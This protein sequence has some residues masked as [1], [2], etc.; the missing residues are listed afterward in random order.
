MCRPDYALTCSL[1]ATTKRQK[2]RRRVGQCFKSL[3][4]NWKVADQTQ[5]PWPDIGTQRHGETFG[6]ILL[7]GDNK[8]SD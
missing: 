5:R 1:K 4:Q 6:D 8:N 2:E 3:H 7:E